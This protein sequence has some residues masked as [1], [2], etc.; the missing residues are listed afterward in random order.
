MTRDGRSRGVLGVVALVVLTACGSTVPLEVARGPIEDGEAQFDVAPGA[1]QID[2]GTSTEAPTVDGEGPIGPSVSR[3]G[4]ASSTVDSPPESSP[5]QDPGSTGPAP[6]TTG[7][8]PRAGQPPMGH[9]ITADTI[10]LGIA[11]VDLN[12]YFT[13]VNSAFGTDADNSSSS[14]TKDWAELVIAYVN[15]RGGILGRQIEPI[16]YEIGTDRLL[17]AQGRAQAEQEMCARFTEDN[18]VFSFIPLIS[19]EGVILECARGA[20]TPVVLTANTDENLDRQRFAEMGA[21]WF[22][23]NWLSGERREE[24]MVER[25]VAQEWFDPGSRV[26][27]MVEDKPAY[28]RAVDN[29]LKPAL[30]ELGIEVVSEA[31]WPDQVNSPW[32]NYVLQFQTDRVTHVIWSGCG[33]SAIPPGLFMR[34]A[35]DQG[36]RARHA[37]G[38]EYLM[39]GIPTISPHPQLAGMGGIGWGPE[40][41]IGSER[42]MAEEPISSSD[43]LCREIIQG[44]GIPVHGF[45]Y[46]E[47]IFFVDA[48]L[49]NATALNREGFTAAAEGL[50]TSFV[51]SMTPAT[52]FGPDRHD[53]TTAV[54]DVT[55]DASCECIRYDGPPRQV[56]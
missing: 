22:R 54:W 29:G 14:T 50:S 51:S 1:S 55:F 2:D 47:F 13:L 32:Q 49:Q 9:G 44:G 5:T 6:P 24:V 33:C 36:Y 46:C 35:E 4:T 10:Q 43:A 20:D 40:F 38:T 53:G 11:W 17:T 12:A 8:P 23:P 19:N 27:I 56:R 48:V 21:W 34:A 39:R 26:G 31:A 42:A 52:R 18:Q 28:R 41:D 30:A 7:D 45:Q 3:P 25:L 37:L 15:E 16:Y